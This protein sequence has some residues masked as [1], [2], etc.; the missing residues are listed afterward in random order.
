MEQIKGT[1]I[2][3]IIAPE[4]AAYIIFDSGVTDE[5]VRK[6]KTAYQT[7]DIIYRSSENTGKVFK[8][9]IFIFDDRSGYQLGKK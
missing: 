9:D 7:R 8:I 4:D 5:E 3:R 2:Y 6:G 1:Y